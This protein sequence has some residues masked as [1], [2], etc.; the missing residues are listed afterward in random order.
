[1]NLELNDIHSLI[2]NAVIF[3]HWNQQLAG[4]KIKKLWNNGIFCFCLFNIIIL[5]LAKMLFK[6]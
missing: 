6:F 1:M 3:S 5:C 2:S 4:E